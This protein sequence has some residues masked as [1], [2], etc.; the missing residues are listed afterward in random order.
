[1]KALTS[2]CIESNDLTVIVPWTFW[3]IL[4]GQCPEDTCGL[5]PMTGLMRCSEFELTAG[6]ILTAKLMRWDASNLNRQLGWCDAS[7]LIRKLGWY[8]LNSQ[9]VCSICKRSWKK[10][11]PFALFIE[12]WLKVGISNRQNKLDDHYGCG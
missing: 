10:N 5:I 3:D 7:N 9:L 2:T 4:G 6:L 8:A 12:Y 11:C 1:M